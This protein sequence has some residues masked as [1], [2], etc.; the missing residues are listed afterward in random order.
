M[1]DQPPSF[2]T[3]SKDQ[4]SASP[5]QFSH[6]GRLRGVGPSVHPTPRQATPQGHGGHRSPSLPY[7]PR[8]GSAGL[9]FH[10][11]QAKAALLF[12]YKRVLGVELP[13]LNE[14]VQARTPRKIPVVL[15]TRE[16]SRLLDEVNGTMGLVV[17]LLMAPGCAS[18]RA[19]GF[20]FRTWTWSA[21]RSPSAKGRETRTG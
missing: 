14:V 12:L 21:W 11:N 15:T 20:A 13:W 18:W 3:W 4:D 17:Q 19:C 7:P 5:P 8:Q 10:Q 6:R 2:W 9:R 1:T 16:V